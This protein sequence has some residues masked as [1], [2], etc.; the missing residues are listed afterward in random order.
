MARKA[1]TTPT[2]MPGGMDH[3]MPAGVATPATKHPPVAMPHPLMPET[4]APLTGQDTPAA[5]GPK[6][7]QRPAEPA[8]K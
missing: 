5:P 3:V 6:A 8:P 7:K 2:P 1:K 4:P